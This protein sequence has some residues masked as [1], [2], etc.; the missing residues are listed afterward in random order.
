ML[1]IENYC[2]TMD[3]DYLFVGHEYRG[4]EVEK[5]NKYYIF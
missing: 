1:D 4:F 2:K 3:C 5:N